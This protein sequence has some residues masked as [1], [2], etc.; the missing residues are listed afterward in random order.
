MAELTNKKKQR[1]GHRSYVT[2]MI[3]RVNETLEN[4]DPSK[5]IKLKQ[6]KIVL[7]I[8]KFGGDASQWFTF[9]DNS[10]ASIHNNEELSD[11][12]RFS[13][14]K[15]LLTGPAAATVAGL[16]LTESNY[17]NA[18]ELLKTRLQ[19]ASYSE[20]PHGQTD[21]YSPIKFRSKCKQIKSHAG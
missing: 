3:N 4:Y 5:E 10:V 13:Y 17:Q 18:V 20:L 8:Q 7:E 1:G 19:Q 6:H 14:L 2:K 15:G 12:E 16:T 9:W 11:V 21:E